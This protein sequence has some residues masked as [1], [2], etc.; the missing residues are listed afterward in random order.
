[1]VLRS[2]NLGFPRKIVAYY[3]FFCLVAICW[4]AVGVFV[5]SHTI[6]S[7][8]T[9]SA[10]LSRLGKASAAIEIEYVRHGV[11]NLQKLLERSQISTGLAYGAIVSPDGT[12]LAHTDAN[13]VGDQ[14]VDPTGERLRWGD[15]TS[16]HFVDTRGRI[17]DEYR[18]ALEADNSQFGS[19]LFAVHKPSFGSTIRE[20]A[21]VAPLAILIPLLLIAAGA[22]I[23]ARLARPVADIESQLR[24]IAAQTPTDE[25]QLKAMRATDAASSG[26]NR[27][28]ESYERS[29]GNSSGNDLNDRLAEA[30]QLR[31]KNQL[32]DILQSLP[33]GVAVT[34]VE[35]RITYTNRAIG[36]LMG[37]YDDSE[38]LNDDW[39]TGKTISDILDLDDQDL[40]STEPSSRVAVSEIN[41]DAG[42]STR[43][44]RVARQPLDD[45]WSHG[46]IWSVR[47]VTQQKLSEKMRDQFMDTATH[48]LRTPLANIKAYA[49]TL[50]TCDS[51]EVS[52][53]REFCNTINSEVTRLARFVDDLLSISSMEVGALILERQKVELSR[54][55]DEV[56]SKVQP[57]M[58]QKSID[59]VVDIPEKI[60]E[61]KLDKDKMSAVIVNLL[62]NAAKYTPDSGRVEMR[63]AR[64]PSQLQISIE[65]TGFGISPE[66]L[67]K[68]FDKFFRSEDRRV[69]EEVGTGLGLSLAVEVVRMHGGDITVE[70]EIDKGSTFLISI[71][72]E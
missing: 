63:V 46:Y 15:V 23:L 3:L 57:L 61:L 29:R 49:E 58:Q 41:R 33:D 31:N 12:C 52:E 37:S 26:W 71:P 27:V 2:P 39:S 70:S 50:A 13:L 68:V 47:D 35:G 53:Q 20:T 69:L 56:V 6:A 54:L 22:V 21:Q 17:L 18:V 43:V 11:E 45:Q 51:I 67:P 8:R 30:I 38:N 32:D 9:T 72:I 25:V 44:L 36:A 34:D 4:L 64:E 28:V 10:C 55:F 7:S 5:V 24:A 16:V 65:D 14:I 66:E 60:G 59:F 48:E 40:F 1:M 62:G 42:D 19:L